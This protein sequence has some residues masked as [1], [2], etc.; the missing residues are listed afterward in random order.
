MAGVH[1]EGQTLI[2]ERSV[3]K[4]APLDGHRLIRTSTRIRPILKT[5]CIYVLDTFS[6]LRED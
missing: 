3:N 6:L 5:G 2:C 1:G 4:G